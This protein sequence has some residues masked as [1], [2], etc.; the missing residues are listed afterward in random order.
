MHAVKFSM[1]ERENKSQKGEIPLYS[2]RDSSTT[3]KK[4]EKNG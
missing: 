4:N 3:M 2:L 1:N